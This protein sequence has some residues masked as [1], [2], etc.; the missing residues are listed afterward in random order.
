MAQVKKLKSRRPPPLPEKESLFHWWA[1]WPFVWTVLSIV[2]YLAY[3]DSFQGQLFFDDL[4][5]VIGNPYLQTLAN[6]TVREQVVRIYPGDAVI[7]PK[8]S[9]EERRDRGTLGWIDMFWSPIDNPLAGRPIVQFTFTVNHWW[10]TAMYPSKLQD[11]YGVTQLHYPYFHYVNLG[12]HI[13]VGLLLW[14]LVRHIFWAPVFGDRFRVTAPYW[15]FA[16]SLL[17]LVHPLNTE[18]VVYVTQR[19]ELVL[20]FFFLLTFY[21]AARSLEHPDRPGEQVSWQI[22]AVIAC[23]LG[24]ASKENMIAAPLLLLF[25]ERAFYFPSS[26]R[27]WKSWVWVIFWI[28][29]LSFPPLVLGARAGFWEQ[30]KRRWK[31]YLGIF[32]TYLI[33]IAL[34]W[35]APRGESVGFHHERMKW[36]EYLI[37]QCWCL[38]RYM[39]LSLIPI[40]SELCVDYGRRPVMDFIYTA[41]GAVMV[42][43]MLAA[44]VWGFVRKPWVAFLGCWYFFILA[45]TSSFVPIVTEVGAERRMYL[46]L[47]VIMAVALLAIAEGAKV[48]CRRVLSLREIP[49]WVG[50]LGGALVVVPAIVFAEVSHIRNKDYNQDETLYGHIVSVFPDNDRGNNNFAKINVD[51]GRHDRAL[52][53]LNTAVYIDPEYSDAFTNRGIIYHHVKRFD[54]A[55]QNATEAVRWNPLN[56]SA[57]NNRGN[58][59]MEIKEFDRAVAD[60][61]QV[62]KVAPYS[63]DGFFGRANVYFTMGN[64]EEEK[65]SKQGQPIPTPSPGLPFYEKALA[66]CES[67]LKLNPNDY[68]CYNTKGNVLKKMNKPREAIATFDRA[69]EMIRKE[70]QSVKHPVWPFVEQTMD[71]KQA[72]TQE[73]QRAHGIALNYPHRAT[74]A[75]IFGNRADGY[76]M[77]WQ[78]FQKQRGQAPNAPHLK[79]EA[80]AQQYMLDD[81]TR[82]VR[83]D[84]QN[85]D[86]LRVRGYYNIQLQRWDNAFADFTQALQFNPN[87]IDA[88]RGRIQAALNL[89]RFKELW[90]DAK[91]LRDS[92]APLSPAEYQDLR[93]KT[94][95]DY[96]P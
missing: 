94:N 6:P 12:C 85:P 60:F 19:T 40:G 33:L 56:V 65:L 61:S 63:S 49:Q 52:E 5:S 53:L 91:R 13:A 73:A 39:W 66:D 57:W 47:M 41:P 43:A 24:M 2:G 74:L 38:W 35:Q 15:A 79:G 96:P 72:Y 90:E 27:V 7:H 77:L 42:F 44:T 68:K 87:M 18:T 81:L 93:Q 16:I 25:F 1:T 11:F 46:P 23:A 31:F 51:L 64:S 86:Y 34:M 30:F 75:A 95:G 55:I 50:I 22:G 37:T 67:A 28:L 8:D 9:F 54:V 29:C 89:R 59:F 20:A 92:G 45:P 17:W 3:D 69:I 71:L 36:Y 88:M 70:A 78:D 76:R 48:F 80:E 14:S 83:F 58:A 26:D 32:A 84:P 4:S 62:I 82:A 10:A 21:C